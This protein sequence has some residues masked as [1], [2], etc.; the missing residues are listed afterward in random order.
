G[1]IQ[2]TCDQ[3]ELSTGPDN[4]VCRAAERLRAHTGC[5]HGAAIRLWKRIPMAAGLAGGST[6]AAA[7]PA[8]LNQ[9]WQVGL[10]AE[11]LAQLGADIGS[12]VPYFFSTPAAWCTGRGEKVTPL[13]LGRELH[14][15]LA[16][17]PIGLSTAE[18]YRSAMVPQKPESGDV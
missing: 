11:E 13:P 4:L 3:A 6:D 10:S 17:P 18:V 12:D 1:R 14:F 2:L 7:A 16:C 9:L 8:G 15:V 5:M